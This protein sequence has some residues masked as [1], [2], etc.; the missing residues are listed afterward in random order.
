M[1]CDNFS[2]DHALPSGHKVMS[3]GGG[4]QAWGVAECEVEVRE[5]SGEAPTLL[6][7]FWVLFVD[8]R[9]V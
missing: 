4:G 5:S 7:F 8:A 6:R 2:R 3:V 9:L 1:G